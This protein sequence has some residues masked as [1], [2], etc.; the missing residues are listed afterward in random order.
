MIGDHAEG[1]TMTTIRTAVALSTAVLAVSLGAAPAHAAAS[2]AVCFSGT[3]TP[4]GD[5]YYEVSAI[6]CDGHSGTSV[7][8]R[9]GSAAGTYD[10]GWTFVWNGQLGADNCT[11]TSVPA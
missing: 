7:T 5:G 4:T 1:A 11:L 8:I 6:G 2:D 3:R 9:F 10:C